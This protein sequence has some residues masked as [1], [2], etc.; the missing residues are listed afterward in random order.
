M[1]LKIEKVP[2]SELKSKPDDSALGFGQIFTDHMLT[3][4]YSAEKG[5]HDAEIKKY[6]AF[7]LAPSAMA[8]HYGQAIFEGL[9]AY[10]GKDDKIYLFRPKIFLWTL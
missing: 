5:W 7:S 10:R 3:M 1:D 2:E 6:Q 8:L 4:K 9:K